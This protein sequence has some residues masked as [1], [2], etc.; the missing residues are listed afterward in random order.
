M[1]TAGR[2]W[3]TA[4]RPT[5]RRSRRDVRTAFL[6]DGRAEDVRAALGAVLKR[7]TMWPFSSFSAPARRR[8]DSCSSREQSIHV[9]DDV[10]L[11]QRLAGEGERLGLLV[12]GQPVE[13]V[14]A[15]GDGE[16]GG[17]SSKHRHACES[18][19]RA[20]VPQWSRGDAMVR[21]RL[22]AWR[23]RRR[24]LTPCG[25][26]HGTARASSTRRHRAASGGARIAAA[27]SM[28]KSQ[29]PRSSRCTCHDG[30][31][32]PCD[33]WAL[34]PSSR[35]PISCAETRP[36]MRRKAHAGAPGPFG[37]GRGVDGGDG[38]RAGLAAD[39]GVAE[40]VGAVLRVTVD[41]EDDLALGEAR[42]ARR[43]APRRRCSRRSRPGRRRAPAP[44]L[45]IASASWR[46]S[47]DSP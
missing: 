30:R 23:T 43:G 39:D 47:G 21:R 16:G 18:A 28:V 33:A 2:S 27:S 41:A 6:H 3:P 4:R 42:L 8:R 36:T 12:G 25:P 9:A 10:G 13:V 26:A 45:S 37:D 29:S 31:I 22:T 24:S 32:R 46:V 1:T 35:C 19:A 15:D 7:R 11:R 5:R 20:G 38:V 14:D 44:R 34:V 17:G 40:D